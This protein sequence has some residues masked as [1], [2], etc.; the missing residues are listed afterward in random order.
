MSGADPQRCV[1]PGEFDW[2]KSSYCQ[3]YWHSCASRPLRTNVGVWAYSLRTDVGVW[4]YSLRTD[5]GV[6]AYSDGNCTSRSQASFDQPTSVSRSL[7]LPLLPPLP[8]LPPSL[9]SLFPPLPLH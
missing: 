4:A 7:S 6:W 8:P 3:T 1:R 9:H 2:D 5:V